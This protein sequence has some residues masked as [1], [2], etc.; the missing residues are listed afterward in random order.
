MKQEEEEEEEE[1]EEEE[2]QELETLDEPTT[3]LKMTQYQGQ[4]MV[5]KCGRQWLAGLTLGVFLS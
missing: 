1:K 5:V 4:G 3:R 2:E